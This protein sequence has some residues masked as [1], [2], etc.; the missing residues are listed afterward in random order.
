MTRRMTEE[1]RRRALEALDEAIAKGIADADAGRVK[2][3]EVVFAR[4][5]AR[6]AAMLPET[7]RA[8]AAT[9]KPSANV[10]AT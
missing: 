4:L 8:P 5:K 6:Y 3:A 7:P 10:A 9:P 1:D 2:P